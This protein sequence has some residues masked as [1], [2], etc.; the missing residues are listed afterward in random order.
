MLWKH[1]LLSR[2]LKIQLSRNFLTSTAPK[3]LLRQPLRLKMLRPL[4]L[5]SATSRQILTKSELISRQ[6]LPGSPLPRLLLMMKISRQTPPLKSQS[7]AHLVW[8]RIQSQQSAM[9]T[10]RIWLISMPESQM[11]LLQSLPARLR[12]LHS[13]Q[14]QLQRPMM[15]TMTTLPMATLTLTVMPM[16]TMVPHPSPPSPL[17]WLPPSTPSPSERTA[18]QPYLA[19]GGC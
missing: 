19:C 10:L 7:V 18:L 12:S 15:M 17:L 14:L 1:L 11:S 16:V 9:S 4:S 2:A 5:R 3:L 6:S 13:L 8:Q